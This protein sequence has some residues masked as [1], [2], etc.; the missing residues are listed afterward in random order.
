MPIRYLPWN[1][2]KVPTEEELRKIMTKEGMKPYI[3][4]ME[5]NENQGVHEHDHDECRILITGNVEF[6]A[7]GRTYKLKPGDR[8]D[9]PAKTPHL[10]KNLERGQSV[11]LCA[12]KGKTVQIE[13]Y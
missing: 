4:I 3:S 7:E 2:P 6:S 10:A 13:I 5:K 11:L 8:I 9:L 1:K 12:T